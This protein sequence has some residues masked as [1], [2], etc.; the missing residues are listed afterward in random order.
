MA[1]EDLKATRFVHDKYPWLCKRKK[2]RIEPQKRQISR[3][4]VFVRDKC[5]TELYQSMAPK[6]TDNCSQEL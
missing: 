3:T 6:H 1:M 2:S 4:C 5:S